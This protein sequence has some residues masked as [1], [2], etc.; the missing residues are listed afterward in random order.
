MGAESAKSKERPGKTEKAAIVIP[1]DANQG[2]ANE[3]LLKKFDLNKD[4]KIDE[5]EIAAAQAKVGTNKPPTFTKVEE[6]RRLTIKDLYEGGNPAKRKPATPV[7][8]DDFLKRYD[9]NGDGQLDAAEIEMIKRDLSQ[10]GPQ[11]LRP[12]AKPPPPAKPMPVLR[13]PVR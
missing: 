2:N 4:G 5:A 9:V 10:G 8:S 3:L 6:G 13:T 12:G 7:N 11:N 1:A